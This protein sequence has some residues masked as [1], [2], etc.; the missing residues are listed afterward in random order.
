M[1]RLAVVGIGGSS[2]GMKSRSL[3]SYPAGP[4]QQETKVIQLDLNKSHLD[5]RLLCCGTQLS[6]QDQGS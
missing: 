1:G 4:P 3:P 6:R 5:I 2:H